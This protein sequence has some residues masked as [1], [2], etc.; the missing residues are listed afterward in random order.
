[1]ECA[2]DDVASLL[3]IDDVITG[4]SGV[5]A[6]VGPFVSCAVVGAVVKETGV[7][8]FNKGPRDKNSDVQ[9]LTKREK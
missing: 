8:V 9:A 5:G 4:T 7:D 1:M 3:S 6:D 2:R